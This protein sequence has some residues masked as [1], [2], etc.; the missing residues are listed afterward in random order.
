MDAAPLNI[1]GPYENIVNQIGKFVV[2]SAQKSKKSGL[3]G[4]GADSPEGG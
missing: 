1:I 4:S 3:P 2:F